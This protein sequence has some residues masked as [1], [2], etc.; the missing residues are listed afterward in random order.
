MIV[1]APR[2][3][4]ANCDGNAGAIPVHNFLDEKDSLFA[5]RENAERSA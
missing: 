5:F 4:T 1:A 2:G 3:P